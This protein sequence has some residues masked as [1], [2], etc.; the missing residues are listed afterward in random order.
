VIG[1]ELV[2][3]GTFDTDSD[4]TLTGFNISGGEAVSDGSTS[5]VIIQQDL[6]TTSGKVYEVSFDAYLSSSAATVYI[7]LDSLNNLASQT[8]STTPV[9]MTKQVVAGTSSSVGVQVLSAGL[10]SN[11]LHIDNISVKEI[12]P[13]SVSI[14]MDGRMTYADNNYSYEVTFVDWYAEFNNQIRSYVVTST[15]SGQ[16]RFH[17][18]N[19]GVFD[20]IQSTGNYYSPGILVPYNIASRHG[21]T[22]INGATDGTALTADTTPTALPDMSTTDLSLAPA[23]MGTVKLFRVWANDLGDDGIVDASEP[24]EEPSL[25]LTFD[26]SEGSFTVLDWSE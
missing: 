9:T 15:G 18:A 17:Q 13:L 6:A 4:W 3:N 25:S 8:V 23:Y 20:I 1:S 22:F 21:S 24:S 2:T 14:Q 26:G 7:R 10:G 11:I 12:D 19:A 5:T 16:Q